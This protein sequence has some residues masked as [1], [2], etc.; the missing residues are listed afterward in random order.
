MGAQLKQLKDKGADN[1]PAL[2]RLG[3]LPC[4]LRLTEHDAL[5]IPQSQL[6]PLAAVMGVTGE[7]LRPVGRL[8]G[9]A[10]VLLGKPEESRAFYNQALEVCEKIRFRPEIALTRLDLAE[11]MLEHYPTSERRQLSTWT[12]P[13][14]SCAR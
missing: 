7:D 4:M 11:L 9:E 3:L 14:P 10:S 13:S 2:L 5:A 1:L 6:Q 8:L 12:S